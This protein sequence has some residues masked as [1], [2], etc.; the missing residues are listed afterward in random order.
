[1]D[2]LLQAGIIFVVGNDQFMFYMD[3]SVKTSFCVPIKYMNMW[4][5]ES[6][7]LP[8]VVEKLFLCKLGF[9]LSNLYFAITGSIQG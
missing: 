1:M 5:T 7:L 2:F 4:R 9:E 8:L 6:S 3:S